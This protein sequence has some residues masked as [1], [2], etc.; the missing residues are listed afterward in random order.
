MRQHLSVSELVGSHSQSAVEC[1]GLEKQQHSAPWIVGN[2]YPGEQMRTPCGAV[3]F[4][5][6]NTLTP[7]TLRI[8]SALL[9]VGT[10]VGLWPECKR[11]PIIYAPGT[12]P[13]YCPISLYNH[14]EQ[15][16][17]NG[18][19]ARCLASYHRLWSSQLLELWSDE[20]WGCF[21]TRQ[22]YCD[23]NWYV[24]ETPNGFLSLKKSTLPLDAEDL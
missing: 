19:A 24:H 22:L 20:T 6:A 13:V 4:K 2:L 21:V 15:F 5:M 9:R 14:T 23:W 11:Q 3:R 18:A 8:L 16:Y 1:L 10:Q 12:A 17:L 7:L